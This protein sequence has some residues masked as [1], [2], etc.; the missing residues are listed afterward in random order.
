MPRVR[1]F[2]AGALL[3]VRHARTAADQASQSQSATASE[4]ASV[5]RTEMK[6]NS[7]PLCSREAHEWCRVSPAPMAHFSLRRTPHKPTYVFPP[8]SFLASVTIP[9]PTNHP[10]RGGRNQPSR[11]RPRRSSRTT[12]SSRSGAVRAQR[13]CAGCCF[14]R[15]HAPVSSSRHPPG[16]IGIAQCKGLYL[17]RRLRLGRSR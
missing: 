8:P 4:R 2:I 10:Q 11:A 15:T 3:T 1:A 5:G 17:A 6:D 9:A 7:G 16:R 14:A 13:R 12:S